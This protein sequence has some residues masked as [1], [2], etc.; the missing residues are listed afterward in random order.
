[1][2]TDEQRQEWKAIIERLYPE[3]AEHGICGEAHYQIG[4][5]HRH[6]L[7]CNCAKPLIISCKDE[8]WY[9]YNQD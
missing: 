5:M 6:D 2:Y 9:D 3:H 7:I 4:L 8:I 1:M